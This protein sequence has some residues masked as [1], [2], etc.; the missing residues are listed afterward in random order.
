MKSTIARLALKCLGCCAFF[1]VLA[2][3]RTTAAQ[4]LESGCFA[5]SAAQRWLNK[6]VLANRVLD[7]METPADW[8]V[9]TTGAPEVVDARTTQKATDRSQAVAEMTFSRER[10][11]EGRPSL[12]LRMP[13]R[14][15]GPGPKNGRCW[16]NAGVRR[17]FA[18]E[19]WRSFNRISLWIQP[20]CP[21]WQVVSLELRL[22]NEGAEKL[23]AAFGQ[24]GETTVVLQNRE[25]NH[26]V[27]EI[28]NVARDKVTCFE[29][30]GLMCGHEP[31]AADVLTYDVDHLELQQVEPDYIEGWEVWPG[32]IAYSHAG[33]QSGAS[34]SA[35]ASGLKTGQFCLLDQWVNGD[36][37]VRPGVVYAQSQY[38]APRFQPCR[39]YP[40]DRVKRG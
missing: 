22:Y 40:P 35:V 6:K 31:E 34:K 38:M 36:G 27:W 32:R 13:A 7:D 18:G 16:A 19:D 33:Y 28:G 17:K 5:D 39:Q 26:V 12:R 4:P 21:G 20:D 30:C 3:A 24:E 37:I 29:I 23:P 8:A 1:L 14:L 11:R 25:W 10:S 15:D 2:M 9:F